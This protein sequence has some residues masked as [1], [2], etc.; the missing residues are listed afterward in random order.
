[1]NTFTRY[2]TLNE[3]NNDEVVIITTGTE[4]V[5]GDGEMQVKTIVYVTKYQMVVI[6]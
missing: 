4:V 3:I 6:C 2:C 5:S 1:M